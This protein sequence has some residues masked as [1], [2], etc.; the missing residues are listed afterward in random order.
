MLKLIVVE[1]SVGKCLNDFSNLDDISV[2]FTERTCF[3][4]IIIVFL[5]L[6]IKPVPEFEIRFV[7]RTNDKTEKLYRV[8]QIV[9]NH[10]C[11]N[12][13]YYSYRIF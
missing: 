6:N 5:S 1:I 2:I 10:C 11:P 3:L 8:F 4:Q 12:Q 7:F 13:R 9:D